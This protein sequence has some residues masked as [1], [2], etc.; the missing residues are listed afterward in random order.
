MRQAEFSQLYQ[1]ASQLCE[2]LT[3]LQGQPKQVKRLA[4]EGRL[5]VQ[6][7]S[8]LLAEC[9]QLA[10]SIEAQLSKIVEYLDTTVS[11]RA[12]EPDQTPLRLVLRHNRVPAYR[13]SRLG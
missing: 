10:A 1:E 6:Q 8:T 3:W 4:W 9:V 12:N 5:S 7:A 2:Q 11:I 13:R